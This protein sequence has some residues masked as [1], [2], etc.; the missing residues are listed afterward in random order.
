MKDLYKIL[1]V[2]ENADESSIKKAYRKLAKE[3][4]PDVTGGDKK[5][6]ERFKEINEAYDVLGD[7]DKRAAYIRLKN[8]PV[9]PDGMPEGFDPETFAQTFGG[10]RGGAGFGGGGRGGV[11]ISDIFA[12]LFADAEG[13]G[14]AGM[15]GMGGPGGIDWGRARNRPSRG[16]DVVGSLEITFA[17]AAL[18][19]RRRVLGGM[20]SNTVEV[21]VPAGVENGSRLRVSGQGAPSPGKGG[22]PGDLYLDINVLP[23]PHLQRVGSNVEVSVPISVTEAALGAKVQVPTLEGPVTLTVPPGSSS[24]AKLRLRGRGIKDRQGTRG[25]QICRIEIVSPKGV[26]EDPELRR[27]FEEIG[28]LTGTKP[29]REF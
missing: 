23:D 17:E 7:K 22:T 14:G 11:D 18:G 26:P 9:R 6:T 4:H 5:K 10:A 15:G 1:G 19:T 8:A 24:G 12:S 29:V 25:D 21:A 2:S 20:G 13:R 28:R 3:N 16:S 27:L